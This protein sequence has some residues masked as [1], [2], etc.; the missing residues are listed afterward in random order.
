MNIEKI[1]TELGFEESEVRELIDIFLESSRSD[2]DLLENAV[3]DKHTAGIALYAHSLRGVASNLG[4]A[5]VVKAAEDI[6]MKARS[7]IF[8]AG[9]ETVNSLRTMVE[10]A[11]AV[12]SMKGS[13][14]A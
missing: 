13:T 5:E 2:L 3:R 11:S 12:I 4:L 7:G 9:F 6:E 10:R 8:E 1:M 14:G